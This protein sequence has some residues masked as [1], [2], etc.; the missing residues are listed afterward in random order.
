M[1]SKTPKRLALLAV[2]TAIVGGLA[3]GAWRMLR[4]TPPNAMYFRN[5]ARGVVPDHPTPIEELEFRRGIQAV[6]PRP[7]LPP[8]LPMTPAIG[9]SEPWFGTGYAMPRDNLLGNVT[10]LPGSTFYL[11]YRGSPQPYFDTDGCVEMHFNRF[12]MRDREDL[13]L[14]K[15]AGVQR[16]VCLGD[17]FTLGWGVRA[18]HNWPVLVEQ[19]LRTGHPDV[20]VINGG[21]TGSAYVDEYELALRNRHGRFAPDLVVVTLCLNDLIITNGKLCHY[22]PEALPESDRPAGTR[23]WWE[24]SRLLADVVRAARAS[25]ALELDPSRDW[26]KELMDL[27]ADDVCYRTKNETPAIYWVGGAPQKALRGMRDWCAE[28]RAQ[29]A[30]VIWPLLQGLGKGRF[31]PFAGIHERVASFCSQEGIPLLDLLPVL[32]DE[33]QEALWVNPADMHPNE[34]AQDLVAPAL[35]GFVAKNL[36]WK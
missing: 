21:G 34:H 16:V 35:A 2:T 28:H 6:W 20:Q 17:S 10:W 11:C 7:D 27:P 24:G 8:G 14:E 29:F 31:Y 33:P 13:T 19:R 9:A 26:T 12:G 4:T 36:G 23:R 25:T 30:V 3:E 15:P 18:E 32:K 5:T 22:R 1:S